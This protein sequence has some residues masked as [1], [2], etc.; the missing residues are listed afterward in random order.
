[1]HERAE[2]TLK[3]YVKTVYNQ[4]LLMLIASLQIMSI[5]IHNILTLCHLAVRQYYWRTRTQKKERSIYS[6]RA[7]YGPRFVR[8]KCHARSGSGRSR[9]LRSEWPGNSCGDPL[10]ATLPSARVSPHREPLS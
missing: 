7:R 5:P 3:R 4:I 8:P 9:H 1:M 10:R 2:F 6:A